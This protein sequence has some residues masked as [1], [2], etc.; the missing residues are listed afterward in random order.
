MKIELD[1]NSEGK[2]VIDAY[3][4][5]SV[6]VAGVPYQDNL[7]ISPDKLIENWG[8]DNF[9]E[10]SEQHFEQIIALKPEIVLLGTGHEHRFPKYDIMDEL[11]G[12]DIGLE[13]MDTGAA[14]RAYNFLVGEGREVVAALLQI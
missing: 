4:K 11:A 5:D 13:I 9:S 12:R 8:P 7:I 3:D 2:N 10:L 1:L 6:T 14:C